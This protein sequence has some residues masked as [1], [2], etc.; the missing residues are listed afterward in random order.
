M[1]VLYYMVAKSIVWYDYQNAMAA[2]T[3]V[4][5]VQPYLWMWQPH[6]NLEG[7]VYVCHNHSISFCGEISK[8]LFEIQKRFMRFVEFVRYRG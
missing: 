6:Y 5:L 1:S 2:T 8:R 4:L 7:T 3:I